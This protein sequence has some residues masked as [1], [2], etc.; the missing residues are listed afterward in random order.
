MKDQVHFGRKLKGLL[1]NAS[2]G[3]IRIS[4]A[5]QV[6]SLRSVGVT[7]VEG[8]DLSGVEICDGNSIGEVIGFAER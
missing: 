6:K 2:L 1:V 3:L 4:Q 5:Y 8:T 7:E